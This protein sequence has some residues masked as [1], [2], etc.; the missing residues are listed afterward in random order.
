MIYMLRVPQKSIPSTISLFHHFN[1]IFHSGVSTDE[2][3]EKSLF[4]ADQC[5]DAIIKPGMMDS[6]PSF[7]IIQFEEFIKNP[8]AAVTDI[9]N[10]F[11]YEISNELKIRLNFYC[12]MHSEFVS[13]HVYSPEKYGLTRSLIYNRYKRIYELFYSSE[14]S[15]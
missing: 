15:S 7:V 10:R 11:R 13:G 1:N 5:F 14:E 3:V 2:I 12:Q 8:L 6:N 9:Y 4:M